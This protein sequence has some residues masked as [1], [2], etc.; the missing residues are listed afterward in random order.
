MCLLNCARVKDHLHD[1]WNWPRSPLDSS[2]FVRLSSTLKILGFHSNW[3][4]IRCRVVLKRCVNVIGRTLARLRDLQSW[5][6][7]SEGAFLIIY[8]QISVHE[9]RTVW[10]RSKWKNKIWRSGHNSD[11]FD[12]SL[13]PSK[14]TGQTYLDILRD[15]IVQIFLLATWPVSRV[16]Q[17]ET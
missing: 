4:E 7:R 16:L 8:V 14:S 6:R 17:I 11:K 3:M 9:L 15:V 5:Q 12:I 13:R 1:S 10:R 2:N